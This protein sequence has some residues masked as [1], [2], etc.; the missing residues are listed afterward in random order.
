MPGV[1]AEVWENTSSGLED[2]SG[3]SGSFGM[4]IGSRTNDNEPVSLLR[5]MVIYTGQAFH[6]GS[7]PSVVALLQSK[8]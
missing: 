3:Q 5:K 4:R 2:L 8:S 1:G 6:S 7:S